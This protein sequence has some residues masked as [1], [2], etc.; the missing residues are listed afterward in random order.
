MADHVAIPGEFCTLMVQTQAIAATRTFNMNVDRASYGNFVARGTSKWRRNE[1]ADIGATLD[2][3]GLVVCRDVDPADEWQF[4]DLFTYM[5]LGTK[6]D[7]IFTL[8]SHVAGD[9]TFIYTGEA[10]ITALSASAPIFGET[11][12]SFSL[13]FTGEVAQTT[14]TV[15]SPPV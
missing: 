7:V 11:T 5:G 10:Y 3:D 14:A 13:L 6:L 12:F 1:V 9:T 4:D 2:G 8:K 15:P